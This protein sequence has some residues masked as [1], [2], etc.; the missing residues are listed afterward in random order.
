M[1]PQRPQ[2]LDEARA[3]GWPV[4]QNADG[5][6][7]A[8][9][10]APAD[11]LPAS[12]SGQQLTPAQAREQGYSVRRTP[13]GDWTAYD[14]KDGITPK[15]G[16]V[17]SAEGPIAFFNRGINR[18]ATA[19]V[20]VNWLD[21]VSRAM[22]IDIPEREPEG[23]I[24]RMAH[25]GGMAAGA[26]PLVVGGAGQLAAKGAQI[27]GV[28]RYLPEISRVIR[29]PFMRNPVASVATEVGSGIGAGAGEE[30]AGPEYGTMGNI[31]GGVGAGM[32]GNLLSRLPI[33]NPRR[34][35]NTAREMYENVSDTVREGFL[36]FTERGAFESAATQLQM[37]TADAERAAA[38]VA[39][40]TENIRQKL[41]PPLEEGG[42]SPA[43]MA[44]DEDLLALERHLANRD[45]ATSEALRT[46]LG[47]TERRIGRTLAEVSHTHE[48]E[49]RIGAARRR[50]DDSMQ[51]MGSR[52]SKEDASAVY[53]QE[54]TE[55]YDTART[56]EAQLWNDAPDDSLS[57]SNLKAAHKELL[58]SSEINKDQ[59]PE[60][61][62]R[63]LSDPET[64]VASRGLGR[65][66]SQADI[67]YESPLSSDVFG[68]FR[69]QREIHRFVSRMGD[70]AESALRAGD[71]TRAR[72]ARK[73]SE[74]GWADLLGSDDLPSSVS[75]EL[76]EARAYSRAL[77]QTFRRGEVGDILKRAGKW[78]APVEPTATLG[79][80]RLRGQGDELAA[81]TNDQ[82]N[83]A[84][85][86][87]ERDPSRGAEAIQDYLRRRFLSY[88]SLADGTY[89]STKA[90][91]FIK[92]ND[93][94]LRR[95][96]QLHDQMERAAQDITSAEGLANSKKTI[97][98][99]MDSSSP[100]D[101]L[102]AESKIVNG[103]E[104]QSPAYKDRVDEWIKASRAA[105]MDFSLYPG[106]AMDELGNR[107]P[108]GKRLL[109]LINQEKTGSVFKELFPEDELA[110]LKVL[111]EELGTSQ[112]ASGKLNPTIAGGERP[113]P[114]GIARIRKATTI[115]ARITGAKLGARAAQGTTGATL[116]AASTVSKTTAAS[117][118]QFLNQYSDKL[119][120]D[121]MKDP[122][123]FQKLLT[124]T[125]APIQETRS[126]WQVIEEWARKARQE[127]PLAFDEMLIPSAIGTEAAMMPDDDQRR[128]PSRPVSSIGPRPG[129]PEA[130]GTM[131][132][133]LPSL[134][135]R[136]QRRQT[137][138][139]HPLARR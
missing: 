5:G 7:T 56:R 33:A 118:D 42:L 48:L 12:R 109:G 110:R 87:D 23:F 81:V 86:F 59:I 18:T 43:Q 76:G 20:G 108:N 91:G 16:G 36:P 107:V 66:P 63:F 121:A 41:S 80:T 88:S 52:A 123:L 75:S 46:Q 94:L 37:R 65:P 70:I 122:V 136:I 113:L 71:R 68:E 78:G 6:W 24:E 49:G 27:A 116:S 21:R 13:E 35:F 19:G 134:G 39:A 99:I 4:V 15:R 34:T 102:K 1:P 73:L 26:I 55:A 60:L 128:T 97:S 112:R 17:F 126:A 25:T 57:I 104:S 101:D 115:F 2:T 8:T 125:D 124:K 139:G 129:T 83:A 103:P 74:A 45:P 22:K 105:I 38:R 138:T 92:K 100:L 64:P 82:L 69:N 47:E 93:I 9:E 62:E 89:D 84:I 111:A 11:E 29:N 137:L 3:M 77:N 32:G 79:G 117:L 51:E 96:P 119:I 58:E 44:G 114:T 50:A 10:P 132:D 31:V 61:A 98:R 40:G 131:G 127:I 53:H 30:I 14:M 106:S 120:M 95:H 133:I 90:R 85:G 135:E 28:G 54:L 67:E 72:Y 130:T